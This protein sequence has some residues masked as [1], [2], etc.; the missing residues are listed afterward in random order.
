MC[1]KSISAMANVYS[2]W[3]HTTWK[4][5]LHLLAAGNRSSRFRQKAVVPPHPSRRQRLFHPPRPPVPQRWELWQRSNT[6]SSG[7][8]PAGKRSPTTSGIS[9]GQTQI[10]QP[11]LF[12]SASPLLP[13]FW[14]QCNKHTS[15]AMRRWEQAEHEQKLNNKQNIKHT[16]ETQSAHVSLS[17]SLPP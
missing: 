10:Q 13:R 12:H 6:L 7:P 17:L 16:T 11:E 9:T 14:H 8:Q 5:K 3:Q 15:Q 4:N 1:I 2:R